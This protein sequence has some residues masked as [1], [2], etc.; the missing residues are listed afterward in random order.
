MLLKSTLIN[1]RIPWCHL[2][3]K[4]SIEHIGRTLK[5]YYYETG[6]LEENIFIFPHGCYGMYNCEISPVVPYFFQSTCYYVL[7]PHIG[8]NLNIV[9]LT[10]LRG[11]YIS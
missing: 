7:I 2:W 11:E 6:E 4:A 3:H 1:V 5:A 8:Q 9:N 10:V